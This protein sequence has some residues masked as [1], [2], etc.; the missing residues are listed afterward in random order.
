MYSIS[1]TTACRHTTDHAHAVCITNSISRT[2]RGTYPC[3]SGRVYFARSSNG[4]PLVPRN[5]RPPTQ[6]SCGLVTSCSV[7]YCVASGSRQGC[8]GCCGSA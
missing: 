4:W 6:H 5:S 1:L 3:T 2:H 8:S 7:L